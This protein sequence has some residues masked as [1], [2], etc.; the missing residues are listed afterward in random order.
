MS[1]TPLVRS[2]VSF[3]TVYAEDTVVYR[4]RP[5]TLVLAKDGAL[6]DTLR[7]AAE[8]IHLTGKAIDFVIDKA[9][10]I[11]DIL[12]GLLKRIFGLQEARTAASSDAGVPVEEPD[13]ALLFFPDGDDGSPLMLVDGLPLSVAKRCAFD[14]VVANGRM[15]SSTELTSCVG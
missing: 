4:D 10:D 8:A 3:A 9:K 14:F 1:S 2:F 13:A 6:T 7:R 5:G 11:A 15:P 12:P